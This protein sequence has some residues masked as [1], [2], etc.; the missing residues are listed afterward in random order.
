[1]QPSSTNVPGTPGSVVDGEQ[2][3]A[4]AGGQAECVIQAM[5]GSN[6]LQAY[7][8]MVDATS[9]V[10]ERVINATRSF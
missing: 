9:H 3:A 1:M 5:E 2:A 7:E 4:A 6:L 10:I 8:N